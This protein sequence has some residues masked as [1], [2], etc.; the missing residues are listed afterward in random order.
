MAG[1]AVGGH[2][3]TD[4]LTIEDQYDLTAD[5]L[6]G[7]DMPAVEQQPAIGVLPQIGLAQCAAIE[8]A[9]G[10]L[11]SMLRLAH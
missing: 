6:S 10:D 8:I 4:L 1:L 7:D 5:N 9:N 2:R 3:D 11:H